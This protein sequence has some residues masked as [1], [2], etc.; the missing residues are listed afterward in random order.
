MSATHNIGVVLTGNATSLQQTLI[1]AGRQVETF[2]HQVES[3]GAT[4]S[5]MGTILKA[6]AAAGAV[7]VGAALVYSAAK[8]AEFETKM[9]NVN[10]ISK[11]SEAAFRAQS[12]AVLEMSTRV[13]QSAA[14]LADGLYDIASS[15]FQGAQGLQILEASAVAASAGLSTTATSSKAIV[16]V[17]NAYGLGAEQATHVSNVLFQGVNV[18]VLS[19]EELASVVG[20]FVGTAAAAGVGIEESTAAIAAMTLT[21]IS[22]AEAGTSLNRV[23][24]GIIQ[25]SDELAEAFKGLHYQSGAQALQTDGLVVVLEKLR[26]ASGGNIET[27]LKWMPE[28]RGARGLLALMANDGKNL[29]KSTDA[30]T[31]ADKREGAARAALNEQMKSTSAQWKLFLN[32]LNAGAIQ[33]GTTLLPMLKSG[34][35]FT[36]D[37]GSA[38]VRLGADVATK[39]SPFFTSLGVAL[40]NV[41]EAGGDAI[42]MLAPLVKVLLAIVGVPILMMLNTLGTTLQSVTGFLA[43]HAEIV[44]AVVAAYVGW[45]AAVIAQAAWTSVTTGVAAASA[46]ITSMTVALRAASASQGIGVLISTLGQLGAITVTSTAMAAGAFAGMTAGI[47]G[48]RAVLDRSADKGKQKAD[49]YVD[50]LTIDPNDLDATFQTMSEIGTRVRILAAE[51]ADTS[52]W[53]KVWQDIN[54]AVPNT[55]G[56]TEAELE[57]LGVRQEMVDRIIQQ[58]NKTAKEAAAAAYDET[59]ATDTLTQAV[60]VLGDETTSSTAKAKAWKDVLDAILETPMGEFEAATTMGAAVQTLTD[61]LRQNADEVAQARADAATV[62]DEAARSIDQADQ[63]ITEAEQGVTQAVQNRTQALRAVTNAERTLQDLTSKSTQLQKDLTQARKDAAAQLVSYKNAAAGDKL[64][65]TDAEIALRAAQRALAEGPSGD[66][67]DNPDAM[68]QLTQDVAH[69]ELALKEAREQSAASTETLNTANQRGVEGSPQVVAAH[70]AIADNVRAIAD[71]QVAVADA[72]DGVAKADAALVIA[73][74]AVSDAATAKADAEEAAAARQIAAIEA[75]KKA[76]AKG[77]GFGADT[78]QGR[79]NREALAG[80]VKDAEEFAASLVASQGEAVGNKAMVDYLNFAKALLR[81]SGMTEQAVT[82]LFDSMGVGADYVSKLLSG[83]TTLAAIIDSQ[84][85]PG[86]TPPKTA[87]DIPATFGLGVPT[88]GGPVGSW[89]DGNTPLSVQEDDLKDWVTVTE[90]ANGLVPTLAYLEEPTDLLLNGERFYPTAAIVKKWTEWYDDSDPR[91]DALLNTGGAQLGFDSLSDWSAFYEQLDPTTKALL[92]NDPAKVNFDFLAK[93]AQEWRDSNPT[94]KAK[95]EVDQ[96]SILWTEFTIDN[97]V[98]DR[99]VNITLDTGVTT[100]I[101]FGPDGIPVLPG[102]RW[103]GIV[104]AGKKGLMRWAEPETGGEA[105]IP[106]NGSAAMSLPTLNTAAGWYG[107]QVVPMG[108]APGGGSATPSGTVHVVVDNLDELRAL[109]GGGVTNNVNVGTRATSPDQVARVLQ[110]ELARP[111]Q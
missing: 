31:E 104:D 97:I 40:H 14:E 52:W 107:Q 5:R 59:A 100:P 48:A 27:L 36:R 79:A 76:E 101:A 4:G 86:A 50:S 87:A 90:L 91:A 99:T 24:Q 73:H 44:A 26:K 92:D 84:K 96:E 29:A 6:G 10:S 7:A 109:V 51:I 12:D 71:A 108:A 17:L 2:E 75:V 98:R 64:S 93:K 62:A 47:V 55:I 30:M 69:A 58:A 102:K 34:I 85:G 15:G 41:V 35:E 20:D 39:L 22:A 111:G 23:L 60:K 13:P 70:Q 88:L 3:A 49:E 53:D 57:R 8:A 18:G 28:I 82:D 72:T 9:R 54:P 43:D 74:Q 95:L 68:L 110:R 105:Y 56:E 66:Q 77:S 94:T 78:E 32:Q 46:A 63:R 42:E 21:G 16:A 25:P 83:D 65:V 61:S 106:K 67:A 81:Q 33:L 38:A 80:Y 45:K 89:A 103:G 1:T 37:F 11:L 19:F